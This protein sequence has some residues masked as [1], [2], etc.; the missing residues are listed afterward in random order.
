MTPTYG[1]GK[2]PQQA[3]PAPPV[4]TA[5][6]AQPY[7]AGEDPA[8]LEQDK[9]S[10]YKHPLFPLLALLFEKCELATQSPEC[11]SSES[12][13]ID[14]QTF[15]QHQ[16]RD[17]KPFFTD[18]KEV[19]DLMVSS[20]QVLRIHLL[21]LEKVQELCK[22]FC[23]RY[24]TCLKGKMQSVVALNEVISSFA[25]QLAQ[26]STSL[27]DVQVK[28]KQTEDSVKSLEQKIVNEEAERE[29]S[30]GLLEQNIVDAKADTLSTIGGEVSKLTTS[31]ALT[32]A[33]IEDLEAA[34][35]EAEVM[36][37]SG[38]QPAGSETCIKVCAG[39]TGR[40][41]TDWTYHTSESIYEDVDISDCGFIT[42]PTVTT[43]IEGKGNHW[44]ASGTSSI[45]KVTTTSF[46]LYL[47]HSTKI[48]KAEQHEWNVEWIAVGYTC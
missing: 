1:R 36:I 25:V 3:K 6:A 7:L 32:S 47:Y 44:M 41:T 20:I 48:G 17:K 43:S 11:P 27:F 28:L 42:I 9:R 15:V 35:N 40:S 34:T 33:Q 39:S 26:I 21:E 5:A 38:E 18:N 4:P 46:R 10:I 8:R 14:I 30:I 23:N 24:I 13:N 2:E 19:D 12:F 22:D 31:L 29:R 37:I 16:Q 45:Y